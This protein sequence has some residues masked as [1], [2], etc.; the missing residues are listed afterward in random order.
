MLPDAL[1]AEMQSS[2]GCATGDIE[3]SVTI[4]QGGGGLKTRSKKFVYLPKVFFD[5]AVG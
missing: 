5:I 4:S 1:G 2:L 3:I